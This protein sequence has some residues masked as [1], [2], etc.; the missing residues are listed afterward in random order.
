MQHRAAVL[1]FGTNAFMHMVNV[2]LLVFIFSR[3]N[4]QLYIVSWML[5]G[6]VLLGQAP[7]ISW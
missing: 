2:A 3:A 5:Y 1:Q 7:W 4:S 6:P